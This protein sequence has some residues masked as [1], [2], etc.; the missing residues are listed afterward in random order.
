MN[1]ARERKQ[2]R[3]AQ[4]TKSFNQLLVLVYKKANDKKPEIRTVH[5]QA[6]ELTLQSR[7][8][9]KGGVNANITRGARAIYGSIF[10]NL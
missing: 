6:N 2:D 4:T 9:A 1:G 3:N 10:F 8:K 5:N 7:A